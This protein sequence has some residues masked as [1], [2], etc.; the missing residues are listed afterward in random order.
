M[1]NV[2]ISDKQIPLVGENSII[3]RAVVVS[4]DELRLL[5]EIQP[6]H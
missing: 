2:R 3:G 1:A 4:T 6:A 5:A